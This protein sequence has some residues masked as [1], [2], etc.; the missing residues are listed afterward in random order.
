[1]W[2]VEREFEICS[3][4]LEEE[5]GAAGKNSENGFTVLDRLGNWVERTEHFSIFNLERTKVEK[6][7]ICG[8]CTIQ[9]K[10]ANSSLY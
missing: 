6:I 4:E 9:N 3:C 8:Y 1:L 7:G 10:W 5:T 2:I